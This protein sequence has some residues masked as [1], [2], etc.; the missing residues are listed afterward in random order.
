META[1]AILVERYADEYLP[2]YQM[3]KRAAL[4]REDRAKAEAPPLFDLPDGAAILVDTVQ[5]Y[6]Q[7][8]NHD[9]VR[10]ENGHETEAGHKRSFAFL[11]MLYTASDRV[12]ENAGCQRVDFHGARMHAVVIEPHGP[13]NGRERVAAALELAEEMIA[14]ARAANK[15]LFPGLNAKLRFRVGIDLGPCVAI[16]SGRSDEREPMFIGSSANHA[17]K[18]AQGEGE[19]IYLSD[20]VR[21]LFGFGRKQTLDEERMAPAETLEL[22]RLRSSREYRDTAAL[23][24]QRLGDWRRDLSSTP[25]SRLDPA[26]FSFHH[27]R[28]PLSTID[29]QQ[30][31]PANSIRMSMVSIFAD[32]DHYTAYIDRCIA[33]GKLEEAVRLLHILRSEFDAV[34]K[35]D[36]DGRKVRFIGDCVHAII[37]EGD[38]VATDEAGSVTLATKCAA[39]LRSSFRLAQ[40]LLAEANQLGLA[41]G[42]ELGFTPVSRIGI[43][44]KRS[45]RTASSLAVRASEQA[46]RECNGLQ[47]KIGPKAYQAATTT[48]RQLFR[49]NYKADDLRYGDVE[50]QLDAKGVAAKVAGASAVLASPV[51]AAAPAKAFGDRD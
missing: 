38:A 5:V 20:R 37:A 30:L 31:S 29:Y 24:E 23:T 9:E 47:T 39:A 18:L 10:L 16:N 41:I 32:L 50:T 48:V 13:F 2:R 22:A 25:M 42:F 36:F 4:L 11:H 19:G 46:Q 14:L 8:L 44:G 21:A 7:A 26:D 28:P 51:F 35:E 12:V 49:N 1:P 15:H 34:V 45:V 6:V 3:V 43:R 33:N 27:H 17:A 40:E